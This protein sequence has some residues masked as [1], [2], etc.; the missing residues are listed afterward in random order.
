VEIVDGEVWAY[1]AGGVGVTS[2]RG[3]NLVGVGGYANNGE[4][5]FRGSQDAFMSR[6]LRIAGA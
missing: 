3:K 5:G 6:L 1:F 4:A 2:S